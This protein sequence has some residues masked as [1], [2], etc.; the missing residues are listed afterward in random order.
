M[1]VGSAGFFMDNLEELLVYCK[2]YFVDYFIH[3][4]NNIVTSWLWYTLY[5]CLLTFFAVTMTLYYGPG[6]MGSGMAEVIAFINGVNYPDTI[7]IP[8]LVT[9]AIAVVLA[10]AGTLAVGKEGPLGHIGANL[11]AG[12]I[13]VFGPLFKFMQNDTK[14]REYI[15]AGASAGVSVAFGAPIGGTLFIYE[16]SF[17]NPFWNF[18]LVWKTFICCATAVFTAC[19]FDGFLHGLPLNW[20]D[21]SLKFGHVSENRKINSSV[22]L[23]AIIIGIISGLLG[24]LFINVNTRVNALRGKILTKK[25]HKIIDCF[26]FTFVTASAFYWFPYIF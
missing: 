8:T 3:E 10:V 25:W 14:K 13:Y 15:A 17:I 23:G 20:S 7:S 11:G 18:P 2:D 21:D 9:K 6:A 19:A 5:S 12:V 24:P 22:I 26:F 4:E 1:L 16:S